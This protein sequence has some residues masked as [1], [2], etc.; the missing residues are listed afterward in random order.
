MVAIDNAPT[1]ETF[2]STPS[3]RRATSPANPAKIVGK[4]SIHALCEEGDFPLA[5]E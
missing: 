5:A 4:I 2:L 3:A 1:I